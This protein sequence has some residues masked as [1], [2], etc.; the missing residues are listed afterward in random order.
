MVNLQKVKYEQDCP[1]NFESE[2][3]IRDKNEFSQKLNRLRER[4]ADNNY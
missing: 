2:N 1:Q 4:L 3:L